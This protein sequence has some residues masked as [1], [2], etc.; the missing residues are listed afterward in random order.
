MTVSSLGWREDF[1]DTEA[2]NSVVRESD[3]IPMGLQTK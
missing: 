2:D 3:I 1:T